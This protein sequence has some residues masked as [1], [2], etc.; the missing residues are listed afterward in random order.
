[1]NAPCIFLKLNKIY[2]WTPEYYD[3]PNNLPKDMPK[4][5]KEHIRNI[6][7][8]ER[9][10]VWITC[11]GE[12]PADIEYLGPITY[13]PSQGF[14][15]YYYPYL[16]REGY[17]SPLVAVKF[18][19]PVRKYFQLK[20]ALVKKFSIPNLNDTAFNPKIRKK[21]YVKWVKYILQRRTF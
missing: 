16:N 4:K 12:N 6:T 15:G 5:L 19:R 18:E 14:P 20:C 7:S 13:Y 8:I 17:L 2:G 1:M 9:R 10:T 3:D 11:E 21:L